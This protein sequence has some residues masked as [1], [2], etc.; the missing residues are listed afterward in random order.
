LTV[1]TFL[2]G[3]E[4]RCLETK[5]VSWLLAREEARKMNKYNNMTFNTLNKNYIRYYTAKTVLVI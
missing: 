3:V 4:N 2:T 5:T 1:N